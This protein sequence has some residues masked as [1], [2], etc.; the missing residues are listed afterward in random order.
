MARCFFSPAPF[1]LG[2]SIRAFDGI[3]RN[4]FTNSV[5]M[6]SRNHVY[7]EERQKERNRDAQGQRL[8]HVI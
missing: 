2:S 4:Y 3:E 1:L 5:E 6:F 7:V 8:R